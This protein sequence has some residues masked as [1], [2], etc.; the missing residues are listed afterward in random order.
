MKTQGSAVRDD[1]RLVKKR[2]VKLPTF[3]RFET[4]DGRIK[5][6]RVPPH[7]PGALQ[8]S[9]FDLFL[10]ENTAVVGEKAKFLIRNRRRAVAIYIQG[11]YPVGA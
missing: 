9:L 5:K 2:I 6:N 4:F 3:W 7:F 8:K 1:N 11:S 10:L